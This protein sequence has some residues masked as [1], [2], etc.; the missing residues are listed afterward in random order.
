MTHQIHTNATVHHALGCVLH[1]VCV[2]LADSTSFR[3]LVDANILFIAASNLYSKCAHY[4]FPPTPVESGETSDSK[5]TSDSH[6]T[7]DSE[8]TVD[9]GDMRET[10]QFQI[11]LSPFEHMIMCIWIALKFCTANDDVSIECVA[12]NVYDTVRQYHESIPC[13][14]DID[15]I[16]DAEIPFLQHIGWNVYPLVPYGDLL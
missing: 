14:F 5:E 2:N 4:K 3:D 13:A 6:E 1:G 8:E 12:D 16:I 7:A 11:P 9:S 15:E 10:N